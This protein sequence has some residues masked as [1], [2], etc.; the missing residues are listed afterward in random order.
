M[1]RSVN[2]GIANQDALTRMHLSE[3]HLGF[4]PQV[5]PGIER[6]FE[7]LKFYPDPDCG[8]LREQIAA[9][10]GVSADMVAV[11]NG[12]DELILMAAL[13][14]LREGALAVGSSATFPGYMMSS[15]LV[16]ASFREVPLS[17]YRVPLDAI[18]E[19]CV[20]A[21]GVAFLCNPHNPAGT[22]VG[23]AALEGF[24]GGLGR[25]GFLAII[26][27][28][29]AEFAGEGFASA[30]PAIRAGHRAIVTRTFSKAYGLAAFRIGYAIGPAELIARMLMAKTSLPFSV[31][32][33]AQVAASIALTDQAF[34]RH[35]VEQTRL[36]KEL[37]YSELERLGV[38][39]VPSDTNFVLVSL[40]DASRVCS[41]LQREFGVLTRDTMVFGLPS[42]ARISVGRPDQVKLVS[43]ALESILATSE[44]KET[45]S[46]QV[47]R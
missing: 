38:F 27:E 6:E 29:Y 32:R 35:V 19:Q 28:A 22:S 39:Y 14:F 40:P 31:N 43:A 37:F 5:W 15:S 33:L 25:K 41:R 11:G 9:V 23:A 13:A 47:A 36:A 7:R 44:S 20:G 46:A 30:L 2:A 42:H 16:N 24:L 12:T 3:N 1:L 26:D 18:V 17:N 4:S 10:H 21:P 34:V 8:A 45:R